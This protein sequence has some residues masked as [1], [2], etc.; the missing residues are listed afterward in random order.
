MKKIATVLIVLTLAGCSAGENDD[1]K[2]F[3]LDSGKNLRG[4][5]EA[6]PEM[7]PYK[8]FV[9]NAFDLS[10]PFKPR[11]LKPS[12]SGGAFEP[13]MTRPKEP[14]EAFSLESL[15]MVGMLKQKNEIYA[16]IK[17]P[18]NTIYRVRVG[19]YLGQNF[20]KVLVVSDTEV[21]LKETVQ[22]SAGDWSERDSS[23][24]LQ[25]EQ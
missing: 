13:D 10:D 18:E 1:L 3:V 16:V 25:Q 2:Q 7:A 23:L 4:K 11:K 20:G 9:Y 21:K 14:L 6:L 24:I 17:T 8:A 5:V 22:D 12:A 15:K 19:N